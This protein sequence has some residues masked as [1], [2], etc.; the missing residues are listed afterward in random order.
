MLEREQVE[1]PNNPLVNYNLGATYYKQGKYDRAK[2]NFTRAAT[3]AFGQDK[4]L[5]EKSRFNLGN[6]FYKKTLEVLPENWEKQQI[7]PTIRKQAVHEVQQAIE[8]YK[9]TLA[10]NTTSERA[11]TN[12]KAAEELLAKLT[13]QQQ[14]QNKQKQDKQDQKKDDKKQQDQKKQK[15]DKP[16]Q[17]QQKQ[18]DQKQEQEKQNQEQQQ[19]QQQQDKQETK[20]DKRDK[21]ESMES[22]RARMLLKQLQDQE[23]KLQKQ[24][25]K[26][27]VK[28]IA[29]PKN[30][31]QKPW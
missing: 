12:K 18:Q 17:D 5:L 3:H 30:S 1:K 22:R 20:L 27:K 16:K 8:Q 26:Q 14:K 11:T 29:K 25:L 21:K 24:L 13:N 15:Q 31:Y 9:N 2:K 4:Q 6:C 28:R 19:N 10:L 7:D 23:K